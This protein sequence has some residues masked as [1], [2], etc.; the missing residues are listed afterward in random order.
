MISWLGGA[1]VARLTPDQKV[2]CSNH[3]RVI[4]IFIFKKEK[5]TPSYFP[6]LFF[7]SVLSFLFST[8]VE[9]KHWKRGKTHT[10]T[11]L[12]SIIKH[13]RVILKRVVYKSI[14]YLD[15]TILEMFAGINDGDWTRWVYL[16]DAPWLSL[17]TFIS[18]WR[19]DVE[20]CSQRPLFLIWIWICALKY[21]C[22]LFTKFLAN[23]FNYVNLQSFR[24][25]HERVLGIINYWRV[26][27]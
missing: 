10:H 4:N 15:K 6:S 20:G 14:Y 2:A 11:H 13:Q 9:L 1:T 7:F 25:L 18:R 27:Y 26:I 19:R 8:P 23:W 17:F 22:K 5:K 12:I 24:V 21:D 3:V 16:G